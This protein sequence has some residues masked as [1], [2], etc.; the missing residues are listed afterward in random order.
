MQ[1]DDTNETVAFGRKAC[2]QA[3]I[4]LLN[5][6][7]HTQT[8]NVPVDAYLHDGLQFTGIVAVQNTAGTN[9]TTT[10]GV[11]QATLNPE[12]AILLTTGE[13]NLIPPAP[14]TGLNLPKEGAGQVSLSWNRTRGA[15]AS[16]IYTSVVSG[17]A[18]LKAN[19]SPVKAISYS[20]TGLVNATIY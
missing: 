19:S 6:S 17:G 8:L 10:G 7:Q 18:Y 14:P 4:F 9:F 3:A 15:A 13:V 1:V 12:S 20:P 2:Q 11:L 5:R 16:N